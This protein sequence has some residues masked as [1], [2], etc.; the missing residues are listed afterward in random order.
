MV[1][2]K[3]S[4]MKMTDR[5]R[6]IVTLEVSGVL[7]LT[8]YG[9][10]RTFLAFGPGVEHPQL[11]LGYVGFLVGGIGLYGVLIGCLLLN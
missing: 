7:I 6:G 10:V 4:I 9:L 8:G 3:L 11:W 1:S 2:S 5:Q